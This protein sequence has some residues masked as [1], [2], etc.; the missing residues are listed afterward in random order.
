MVLQ[1]GFRSALVLKSQ[2]MVTGAALQAGAG[3]G[4][5]GGCLGAV[6]FCGVGRLF[7]PAKIEIHLLR[8]AGGAGCDR[9]R[10][11]SRI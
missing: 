2:V 8:L 4:D 7:Q 9:V 11:E 5:G 6:T 10:L 3:F 1:V